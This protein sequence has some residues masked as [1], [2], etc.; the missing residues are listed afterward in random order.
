MKAINKK[1]LVTGGGSG[2]G[3]SI[4]KAFA[5]KGNQ[6]ILAGRNEDKLKK[7]VVSIPNASYIVCDVSN[8]NDVKLLVKKIKEEYGGID[9]LVN[10]AGV[11]QPHSLT[12]T[13]GLYENAKY[14]M[15]INFLSVVRLTEELLPTLI[16]RDEA[17]IIN[18]QSILSY[19]PSLNIATYSASKAALHSYSQALRLALEKTHP[20]IKLF[21]VFPPYVDTEM[22]RAIQSDKLSPEEVANDIVE[23][24][25]KNEFAIRN[26]KTKNLYQLY[27]Q[28]PENALK[29]LNGVD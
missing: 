3:F 21:E 15:E 26:G 14:E 20:Q 19:L 16:K 5:A 11:A 17:A 13:A 8:Q 1:I 7:A 23:A 10:N 6:L 28:S 4:A 27:L 12:E 9:I 25:E 2:I 22:A 18:I 24:V 29:V